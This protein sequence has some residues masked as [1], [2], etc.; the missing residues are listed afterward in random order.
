MIRKCLCAGALALALFGLAGAAHAGTVGEYLSAYAGANGIWRDGAGASLPQDF[1]VGG[2]LSLALHERLKLIGDGYWGISNAYARGD[3][4]AKVVVSDK[5]AQD[6]LAIY[7]V[8]K[9]RVGSTD[10]VRPN[11]WAFGAGA[12]FR[13]LPAELAPL[14]VGIEAARG[15]TSKI[16]DLYVA[17]RWALPIR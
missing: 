4:G 5:Y 6:N 2:S 14:T 16:V 13:P 12:G 10:R 1:E 11:E 9:Y 8:G 15:Q 17:A 7:L 3:V